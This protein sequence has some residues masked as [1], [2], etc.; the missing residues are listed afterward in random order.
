MIGRTEFIQ[1]RGCDWQYTTGVPEFNTSEQR[2]YK[3]RSDSAENKL[4]SVQFIIY[5][6]VPFAQNH[7]VR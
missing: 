4:D 7:I 2:L 6:N 5:Y 3:L 1:I